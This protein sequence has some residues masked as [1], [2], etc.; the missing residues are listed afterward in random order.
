MVPTPLST[1]LNF[2]SARLD[3]CMIQSQFV[4]FVNYCSLVYL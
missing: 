4:K 1:I 2:M 3:L